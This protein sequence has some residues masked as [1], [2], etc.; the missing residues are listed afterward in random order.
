MPEFED[1]VLFETYGTVFDLLIAAGA[2]V[3]QLDKVL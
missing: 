2:S 3:D 1:G